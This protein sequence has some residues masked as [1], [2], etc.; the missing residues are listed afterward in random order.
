[1]TL[2]ARYKRPAMPAPIFTISE[3]DTILSED[4][5]V[6]ERNSKD[7]ENFLKQWVRMGPSAP[8][9]AFHLCTARALRP[10]LHASLDYSNQRSIANCQGA[11]EW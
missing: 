9:A 4:D 11:P 7:I 6:T 5:A 8:P 2:Y 1:M 3:I 10:A